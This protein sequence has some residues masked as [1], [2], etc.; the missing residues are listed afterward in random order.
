MVCGSSY[1][2]NQKCRFY[3][4]VRNLST[5]NPSRQT[6]FSSPM[7]NLPVHLMMFT[8]KRSDVPLY[9][10]GGSFYNSLDAQ[11]DDA[12]DVPAD[13]FKDDPSV[14]SE[15]ELVHLLQTVRYWGLFIMPAQVCGFIFQNEA[16]KNFEQLQN[17]FPE[18]ASYLSNVLNAKQASIHKRINATISAGLHVSTVRMLHQKGYPWNETACENAARM[19]D[20]ECLMYLHTEGCP[21]DRRT[22]LTAAEH[23]SVTC[24]QYVLDFGEFGAGSKSEAMS[25]AA[26]HGNL[27][28]MRVLYMAGVT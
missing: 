23:N 18:F 10:R 28:C 2:N 25:A 20:V 5:L 17:N 22:L 9:L 6:F 26:K 15:P 27:D 19:N 3:R 1:K 12:F 21:W 13:C 14:E 24:L 7:P 11:D 16:K 8:I 4:F